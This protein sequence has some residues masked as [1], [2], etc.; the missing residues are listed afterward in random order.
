MSFFEGIERPEPEP[1]EP[2]PEWFRPPGHI[3]PGTALLGVLVGRS[4]SAAVAVSGAEVYPTGFCFRVVVRTRSGLLVEMFGDVWPEFGIGFADGRRALA[5]DWRFDPIHDFPPADP[6]PIGP[7]L[8]LQDGY[9][10]GAR[11]DDGY[12]CWA[13]PPEGP[14]TFAC[15]WE[16][17]GIAE[18]TVEVDSAP[19]R[20]AAAR[21][22]VLWDAEPFD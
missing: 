18:S 21:A 6:P 4:D 1:E 8:V 14:L 16:E 19:L 12:W 11:T 10:S 3:L 2:E 22:V 9:H 5:E 15:R 13:L 17:M 20:A 7:L